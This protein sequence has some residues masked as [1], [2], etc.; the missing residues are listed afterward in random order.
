MY[1][2]FTDGRHGRSRDHSRGHDHYRDH[3]H[4]RD[5]YRDHSRGRDR[6][7]GGGKDSSRHRRDRSKGRD[8][9]R[10]RDLSR[11]RYDAS[12]SR[13]NSGSRSN[14]KSFEDFTMMDYVNGLP[15][16][17]SKRRGDESWSTLRN[18]SEDDILYKGEHKR[19]RSSGR[20]R[21]RSRSREGRSER[22]AYEDYDVDNSS[23]FD[24]SDDHIRREGRERKRRN[25]RKNSNE[26]NVTD[27]VPVSPSAK[28]SKDASMNIISPAM[29]ININAQ[30]GS[31]VHLA[32]GATKVPHG[33]GNAL[34][35]LRL[36]PLPPG[37]STTS[38]DDTRA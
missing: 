34:P 19:S 2:V 38:G 3:S 13:D 20:H 29:T 17:N 33:S 26:T 5:H 12:Y 1:F 22:R 30:A 10:G 16:G 6:Y 8:H 23:R 18:A 21:N 4:G 9:S 35:T 14:R 31:A 7:E 15:L 11:G 24:S 25:K 36:E 32:L 27:I 28:L 37:S